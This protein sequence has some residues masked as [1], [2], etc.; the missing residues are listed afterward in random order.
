MLAAR[1]LTAVLVVVAT[2]SVVRAQSPGSPLYRVFLSDGTA[3]ASFG[4]WARVGDR[5]VFSMPLVPGGNAGELHLV[6]LPVQRVDLDRTQRYA[7]S[8]RASHYA[9]TRGEAD[10]AQFSSTVAQTLNQ[11][12]LIADPRQRLATAEQARRTLAGW[13]GAHHG[14]RAGEVREILGVLD[15]VISGL[16]AQAGQRGFDLKL[17]ANT[18]APPSEPLLAAPDQTEVVQS[19]MAAS[20]AVD[21]PVERV[22]LLQTVVMLI[23]RAIDHL[24]TSVASALRAMAVGGIV[25]EQ[26]LDAAYSTLQTATLDEAAR[27]AER[28]DVRGLELLRQRVRAQDEKLGGR[29]PEHLAGLLAT[30]EAHLDAA[31]RLRLAQDQW[32]LAEGR[33]HDYR[34]AIAPY[35]QSL[36]AKRDRFDD[37]KLLA[38][39]LPQQLFPLARELNRHAQFVAL[40]EPPPQLAA[41]H[42]A[43][44]S[45]YSLAENAVQLR[46]DAVE[47]ADVE[48]ARRASAAAAGALMLLDRARA[49]LKTALE[50]PMKIPGR[51]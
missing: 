2:A 19:L 30:V 17:M 31:H 27:F 16:A 33:M 7:D 45:A 48:L 18:V 28:A 21:S 13:P 12:A 25:E 41:V 11:V 5:V 42:A 49:D 9:V 37:I 29:R 6:T 8:V 14:Y 40:I 4:E 38:G 15:D 36:L 47:A 10:F 26:R 23:D 24:P 46:R 32:L 35:V 51:P 1:T 22:S 34:R 44:R 3:L 39:P 43:L 50:P 20:R